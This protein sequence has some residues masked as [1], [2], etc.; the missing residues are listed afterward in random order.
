ME[1][2]SIT[3]SVNHQKEQKDMKKSHYSQKI[4]T[5]CCNSQ[6]KKWLQ[7]NDYKHHW[8]MWLNVVIK[9]DVTHLTAIFDLRAAA[10]SFCSEY[11]WRILFFFFLIFCYQITLEAVWITFMLSYNYIIRQLCNH[12]TFMITFIFFS[13]FFLAYYKQS[14]FGN[15][16]FIL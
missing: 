4:S 16:N 7:I 2:F 13:V 15:Q 1:V 5:N 11:W 3:A 6:I 10:G 8:F 9:P 12:I 14:L